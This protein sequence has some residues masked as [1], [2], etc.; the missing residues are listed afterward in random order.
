MHHEMR[1]HRQWGDQAWWEGWDRECLRIR[2]RVHPRRVLGEKIDHFFI[3]ICYPWFFHHF[4][5]C[6]CEYFVPN[7]LQE[8][9]LKGSMKCQ[10]FMG[11]KS[12]YEKVDKVYRIN[13][14]LKNISYFSARFFGP[15]W[16]HLQILWALGKMPNGFYNERKYTHRSNLK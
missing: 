11:K 7:I 12:L 6:R 2:A 3:F 15:K 8:K 10:R 14:V 5:W 1:P 16:A 4:L 13:I 9:A